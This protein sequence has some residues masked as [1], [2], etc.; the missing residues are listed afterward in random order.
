MTDIYKLISAAENL[1]PVP[2]KMSIED[3]EAEMRMLHVLLSYG[4]EPDAT[5]SVTVSDIRLRAGKLQE[6][7]SRYFQSTTSIKK[8]AR[9][10]LLIYRLISELPSPGN[11]TVLLSGY[12]RHVSDLYDEWCDSPKHDVATISGIFRNLVNYFSDITDNES[13]DPR[14]TLINNEAAL[15]VNELAHTSGGYHW[16]N[17]E[18]SVALH[19]LMFLASYL[20]GFHITTPPMEYTGAV[21][22][23][24]SDLLHRLNTNSS[25]S[26]LRMLIQIADIHQISP[27]QEP[28][29]IPPSLGSVLRAASATSYPLAS[30][31]VSDSLHNVCVK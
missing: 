2:A 13:S 10:L 5:N 23:Y 19:R 25:P 20:K 16:E 4:F 6:I 28:L 1:R 11:K 22:Y 27:G 29:I 7:A 18:L 9:I 12:Y 21:K 15:A 31:L 3:M 30:L 26:L 8:R 17:M 24:T 14:L